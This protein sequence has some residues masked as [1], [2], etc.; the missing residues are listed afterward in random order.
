M[1]AGPGGVTVSSSSEAG[2]SAGP[3]RVEYEADL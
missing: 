1:L 3:G 2:G